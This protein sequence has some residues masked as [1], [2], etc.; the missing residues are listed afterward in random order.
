MQEFDNWRNV[1]KVSVNNLTGAY[2]TICNLS[3][4][5]FINT[6]LQWVTEDDDEHVIYFF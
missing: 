3:K 6:K 4:I 5:L 2:W 1:V